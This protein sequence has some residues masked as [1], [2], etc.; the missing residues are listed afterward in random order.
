MIQQ[1]RHRRVARLTVPPHLRGSGRGG[2]AVQ[3]LDLSLAG[4]RIEHVELLHDWGTFPMDL[5]RALGGGQ[6]RGQVVWSRVLDQKQV[7]E[8]KHRLTYQSGL[9]FTHS[10]PEER[11]ALAVA[12]VRL[13]GEWALDML[14]EHRRQAERAP[15]HQKRFDALCSETLA[16]LRQEIEALRFGKPH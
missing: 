8:G 13:A 5:P 11:A 15:A 16:W 14:R 6:V 7:V 10:T 2:K 1:S 9:A 4:A 12:L 3:L